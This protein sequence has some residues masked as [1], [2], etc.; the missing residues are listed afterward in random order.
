MIIKN[1]EKDV[2]IKVIILTNKFIYGSI[3]NKEN[4]KVVK[5]T[6]KRNP[7]DN[8]SNIITV[9][10]TEKI[11][12]GV[13]FENINIAINDMLKLNKMQYED[14]FK[15]YKFISKICKKFEL[16]LREFIGTMVEHKPEIFNL[17]FLRTSVKPFINKVRDEKILYESNDRHPE[18]YKDIFEFI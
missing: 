5:K 15:E 3:L 13:D 6:T 4:P 2:E 16:T 10:D 8:L 11:E 14:L 17:Y 9:L 18:L 7:E 1:V 12:R